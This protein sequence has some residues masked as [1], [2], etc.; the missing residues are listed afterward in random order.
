MSTAGAVGTVRQNFG[1]PGRLRAHYTRWGGVCCRAGGSKA[2]KRAAHLSLMIRRRLGTNGPNLSA[3]SLRNG[4]PASDEHGAARSIPPSRPRMA[5]T[6]HLATQRLAGWNPDRLV[7][8][9]E[10]SHCVYNGIV[11][12][13]P[14]Y[15]PPHGRDSTDAVRRSVGG[16]D[17]Q[18]G[19]A[20]WGLREFLGPHLSTSCG[21]S[22]LTRVLGTLDGGAVSNKAGVAGGT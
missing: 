9:T 3:L 8:H 22:T 12:R 21:P 10:A 6:G 11:R 5:I 14:C 15:D 2:W 18:G 19:A 17:H 20:I 16:A 4:N 1:R 7:I 13:R